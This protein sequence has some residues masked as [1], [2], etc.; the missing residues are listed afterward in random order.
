MKAEEIRGLG[1]EE[2]EEK[3]AS[4]KK[5]LLVLRTELK[6]GKLEKHHRIAEMKRA[7]ARLFTIIREERRK[8]KQNSSKKEKD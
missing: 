7:I 2:M 4:L 1:I 5:E 3:V 8:E 6:L